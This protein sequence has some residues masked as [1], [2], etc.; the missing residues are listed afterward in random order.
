MQQE[1]I[2]RE[3]GKGQVGPSGA[4]GEQG[5]DWD[6]F[7]DPGEFAEESKTDDPFSR[8]YF[9]HED[10]AVPEPEEVA[11]IWFGPGPGDHSTYFP[12]AQQLD[13]AEPFFINGFEDAAHPTTVWPR[14][15]HD[16]EDEVLSQATAG[17][18]VNQKEVW[19]RFRWPIALVGGKKNAVLAADVRFSYSTQHFVDTRTNRTISIAGKRLEMMRGI[20][21]QVGRNSAF[22]SPIIKRAMLS[23]DVTML[24]YQDGS[25]LARVGWT[26]AFKLHKQVGGLESESSGTFDIRGPGG[27]GL[28]YTGDTKKCFTLI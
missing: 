4:T 27:K 10:V 28:R 23:F 6:P 1:P 24:A 26:S 21:V 15:L 8:F 25:S 13:E 20:A 2:Q 9:S 14:R 12:V 3:A 5:D 19:A 11:A 18:V 17:E 7:E 22:C 16:S